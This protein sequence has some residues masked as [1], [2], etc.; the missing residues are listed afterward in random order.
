MGDQ[1]IRSTWIKNDVLPAVKELWLQE[2]IK[3]SHP[4]ALQHLHRCLFMAQ[5]KTQH[6]MSCREYKRLKL[7]THQHLDHDA[8]TAIERAD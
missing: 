7:D 1:E 8:S 3:A 2:Y 6:Y 5:K 4:Q